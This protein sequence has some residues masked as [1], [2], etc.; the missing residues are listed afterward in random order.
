MSRRFKIILIVLALILE[1]FLAHICNPYPHGM[2]G[3]VS[4]RR[5]ERLGTFRDYMRLRS[6]DTKAAFDKEM[7]LMH[8]HEDWKIYAALGLL[9]AIN[10]TAIYWFLCYEHGRQQ[11]NPTG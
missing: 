5:A 11:T 7:I 10:G 3:D 6:T 2:M 8:R 9:V 1:F 4:Y